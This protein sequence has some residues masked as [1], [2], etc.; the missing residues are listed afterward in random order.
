VLQRWCKSGIRAAARLAASRGRS[1][2]SRGISVPTLL[3]GTPGA[4][5]NIFREWGRASS[6][7]HRGPYGTQRVV[8][9]MAT[10]LTTR[11]NLLALTAL[12]K[13]SRK[14]PEKSSSE[15]Y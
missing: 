8:N 2:Y 12:A 11:T 9:R 7:Q 5:C 15:P 13:C 10:A 3:I 1:L 6:N 4:G 14:L